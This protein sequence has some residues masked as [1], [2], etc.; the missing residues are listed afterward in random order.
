VIGPTDDRDMVECYLDALVIELRG[1]ACGT[2]RI[3]H[4]AEDHLR[5]SVEAGVTEGLSVEDAQQRALERFGSPALVAK[6]L[7]AAERWRAPIPVLSQLVLTLALIAGIGLVGIG[8]SGALADGMGALFGKPFVSADTNG[9]TYT[10]AR[11]ADFREYHPEAATCAAAATAHHF[12]EVVNYRLAAG[13]LGLGVLAGWWVV[14]RRRWMWPDA[15]AAVPDGFGP[16]VGA[17]L[18]GVAA[19]GLLFVSLGQIVIGG[20]SSGA[21]QYL[22]GGIVATLLAAGFAVALLRTV[23]IRTR[24]VD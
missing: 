4:E 21:G 8:V 14:R 7:V 12:D 13:V 5:E 2:S 20:D 23:R 6:R 1:R 11:C 16:I 17:A 15:S 18:F 19:A 9:V 22:S 24:L 10:P 3:L